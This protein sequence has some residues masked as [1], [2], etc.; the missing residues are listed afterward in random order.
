MQANP[1]LE[2][3]FGWPKGRLRDQPSSVVWPDEASYAE[4]G[5][6]AGPLLSA[7]LSF[8]LELQLRRH[9]S[10]DFWC[11]LLAQAVDR[12]DPSRGGTIWITEDI[13]R[14]R[15]GDQA[16]ESAPDAA[17]AASWAKS[18]FLAHT[19][20]EIRTPLNGLLGLARLA[21]QELVD[22]RRPQ[23]LNQPFDSAQSLSSITSD[24]LEVSKTDAG[25]IILDNVPFGLCDMLLAMHHA[26]QSLADV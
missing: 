4:Y 7:G 23:Y 19:S 3:M 20:H 1:Y 26:Y 11:R 2:R 25:K 16:L 8:E 21:M 18:A 12:S 5:R 14:Q 10:S 22:S 17:E 6:Q 24:I 9:D 13:T 15:R